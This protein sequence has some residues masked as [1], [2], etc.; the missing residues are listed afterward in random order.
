MFDDIKI[1]KQRVFCLQIFLNVFKL[2]NVFLNFI[3]ILFLSFMTCPRWCYKRSGRHIEIP[4]TLLLSNQILN[5][6][7]FYIFKLKR[8]NWLN[9]LICYYINILF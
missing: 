5:Y 2:F 1:T 8:L 7:R 3:I 6:F 4:A 9:Y